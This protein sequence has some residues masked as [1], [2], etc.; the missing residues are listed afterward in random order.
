MLDAL[1]DTGK[2]IKEFSA[3]VKMTTGDPFAGDTKIESGQVFFTKKP[4]DDARIHVVLDKVQA[5]KKVTD[6]LV[7]YIYDDGWLIDRQ[8][9]K[10]AE[11]RRQVVKPGDKMNVMKLGE[12][13]LPVPIGQKKE[14]VNKQFTVKVAGSDKSDPADTIH[15]ALQPKAGTRYAHRFGTIDIW[16]NRQSKFPVKIRT[17]APDGSDVHLTNLN[18]VMINPAGGLKE[19]N[20][21]LPK[22]D[23]SNWSIHTEPYKE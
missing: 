12:G 5:G 19:E 4:N 21:P 8:Y 13:P 18:D 15:L 1:D 22:I 2:S 10:T 6:E 9:K 3:K 14:D 11:V 7:E 17:E 23:P 20:L 16:V